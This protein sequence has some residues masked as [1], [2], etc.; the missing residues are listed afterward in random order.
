MFQLAFI[1]STSGRKTDTQWPGLGFN[2]SMQQK[3]LKPVGVG[4]HWQTSMK[5]NL[6]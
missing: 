3:F 2:T 4:H 5:R 1:H 6:Q